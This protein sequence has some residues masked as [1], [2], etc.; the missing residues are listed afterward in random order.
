MQVR[1]GPKR[2]KTDQNN[3][4]TAISVTTATGTA[5]SIQGN[6]IQN[7]NWTNAGT[8]DF[9]GISLSGATVANLGTTTGNTIGA[10]TGTGSITY[11]SSVTAANFYGI[12]I[13][14]TDVVDCQNNTI[15]SITAANAATNATNFFGIVK[16]AVAGTTTISNNIIGS[17][18]TASS[19]NASA[20]SST[21][22]NIQS[23]YGIQ[24]AGTGTITISGNTIANMVNAT[25]NSTAG[26]A[27]L[28]SGIYVS[29]GTNTISNNT[30]RN[31][32]IA[33]ANTSVT[34]TASVSGIV[35]A[36]TTAAAQTVN[37]NTVY[38]LSN[39]YA[40][41]AGGVIGIFY[42][43]ST[44][45]STVNANFI[46]SLSVSASS[47]TADLYGIKIDAGAA[48]YSNNIISLGGDTKTDVYGIYQ[49]GAA[50][51]S[52]NLY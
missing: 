4:F 16:T 46:H 11:T 6:T 36:S 14:S 5:N 48:T 18:T 27:G 51:N 50:S 13:A 9:T 47:T 52:N 39:S 21:A 22:A 40:S 2:T 33:N 8:S 3:A 30:V 19:I 23:V 34:N 38:S 42:G 25:S 10:S 29:A 26:S 45:A 49:T 15:G 35:M 20:A 12:S 43:G 37:G 7:I 41:F 31:L 44:T 24:S 17:T 32:S 28:I 1:L